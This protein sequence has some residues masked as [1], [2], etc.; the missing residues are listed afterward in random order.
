MLKVGCKRLI[1]HLGSETGILG[2]IWVIKAVW[3]WTQLAQFYR[4]MKETECEKA[5]VEAALYKIWKIDESWKNESYYPTKSFTLRVLLI[6]IPDYWLDFDFWQ[7][8]NLNVSFACLADSDSFSLKV[9]GGWV[10]MREISS[11]QKN[12]RTRESTTF[13]KALTGESSKIE[14]MGFYEKLQ[15][16][17][18]GE[19]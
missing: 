16:Q 6:P 7:I 13:K 19:T 5:L 8:S 3:G 11:V 18:I 12:R 17:A 14:K 9:M 4:S 1:G 2:A 15:T 10:I